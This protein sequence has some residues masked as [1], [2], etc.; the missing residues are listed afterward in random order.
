MRFVEDQRKLLCHGNEN[1]QKDTCQYKCSA[2][3][4][5][6]FAE[7]TAALRLQA[8]LYVDRSSSGGHTNTTTQGGPI[9]LPA[10]GL[11]APSVTLRVFVDRSLLEVCGILLL[12]VSIWKS[13]WNYQIESRMENWHP[14]GCTKRAGNSTSSATQWPSPFVQPT[15]HGRLQGTRVQACCDQH[16]RKCKK[17][18]LQRNVKMQRK[19]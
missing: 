10:A 8:G 2:G 9:P 11:S 19:E 15:K 6:R 17:L 3:Q 16:L 4:I 5:R 12:A 14:I 18:A 1:C 7:L 13:I